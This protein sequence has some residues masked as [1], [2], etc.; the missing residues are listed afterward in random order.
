MT[1]D[2]S[3]NEGY[4]TYEPR[5]IAT[6]VVTAIVVTALVWFEFWEGTV[7]SSLNTTALLVGILGGV[8]AAVV[9]F[10]IV[11]SS[12]F[13]RL[14]RS[15]GPFLIIMLGLVIIGLALFP[16]GL[17][18][19]AEIGLVVFAWSLPLLETAFG[20]RLHGDSV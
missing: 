15:D 17:P 18:V 16:R 7:P 1:S 10:A 8:S 6:D 20:N 11:R 5:S 13:R 14:P 3:P 2:R 4:D 12:K 9:G 19:V